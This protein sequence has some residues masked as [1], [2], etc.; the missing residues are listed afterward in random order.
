MLR[1]EKGAFG[2]GCL[3]LFKAEVTDIQVDRVPQP[4]SLFSFLNAVN[5]EYR[6]F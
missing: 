1:Q 6:P 2:Q 4:T 3:F 5:S